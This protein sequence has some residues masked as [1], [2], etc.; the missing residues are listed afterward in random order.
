MI[1][2]KVTPT[3]PLRLERV[4]GLL[5]FNGPRITILL[6][7]YRPGEQGKSMS[8]ILKSYLQDIPRELAQRR[9]S[10]PITD[11][12]IKPLEEL[13]KDDEFLAGSRFSRVIFRSRDLLQQF[14]LLGPV[15]PQFIVGNY[16]QVRP[17]L[18]DLHSPSEF[19]LLK[20]TKKNIELLR[21]ANFRAEKVKLPKGVPD[22]LEEAMP[23]ERP[24]HDLENRSSPGASVGTM[25]G[26]RFGTGTDREKERSHIADFYRLVDRGIAELL[27]HGKAPLVL[28]GVDEDT[29]TYRMI[30]SYPNL[31]S[32][33][34]HGSPNAPV[35]DQDLV[36]QGYAIVRAELLDRTAASLMEWKERL[37]PAR[38]ST[39]LDTVLHASVEGRI[40]KLYV[41]ESAQRTG[42]FS[43]RGEGAQGSGEEDLLNIAAVQTLLHSGVA[44]ELPAGKMPDHA[45][46]AAVF[47]Y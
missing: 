31:L 13:T 12:L 11:E 33:S 26:V 45:V 30:H 35:S 4:Q 15:K 47:R 46:V 42:V 39:D 27:H 34:I 1:E 43:D 2:A 16:F 3:E 6:P 19:Y 38:F 41:D 21:C 40:D 14:D 18:A 20:L 5:R 23:F 32:Q 36:E 22:T 7:P 25:R 10:A 17:L 9:V 29:A 24:D 44:F 37:A 28:A 8:V